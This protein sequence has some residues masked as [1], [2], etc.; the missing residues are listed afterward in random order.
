[1]FR[2]HLDLIDLMEDGKEV[3]IVVSNFDIPES[4]A[5]TL[6]RLLNVI[7]RELPKALRSELL[8]LFSGSIQH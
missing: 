2:S 6:R 5:G 1:M 7:E 3:G 4:W 8:N